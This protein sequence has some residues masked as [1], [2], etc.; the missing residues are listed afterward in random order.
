[1]RAFTLF[2]VTLLCACGTEHE[3]G[4]MT[5]R[6]RGLEEDRETR[7]GI[8]ASA[9]ED[10]TIGRSV[11][12]MRFVRN[13]IG[14]AGPESVKYDAEQDVWFVTNMNGAGSV[15]DG[16]G[17]I[18][19]IRAAHPDSADVFIQGGVNG[20][21]LDGP[22]GMAIHGD[23]LWVAD[24]SVLRAFHRKT[25]APL[26]EIDFAPLGAVQLNDVAIGPDGRV[27]V[28]DTGIM[29]TPKG[30]LHIGPDRVF[31]VGPGRQVTTMPGS[32]GITY[33]NGITWDAGGKRW[34]VV[35]FD[36]F[37]GRIHAIGADGK[38]VVIRQGSSRL[39]G[40]EVLS[41]GAIVFTSWGD[42]T[43]HLVRNGRDE[44]A[45]R[46]I[47]EGADIGID[48]RRSQLAVPLSVLGRVQIWSL[49]GATPRSAQ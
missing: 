45:L 35:T 14:F 42:S 40:V 9:A 22:K 38:A 44:A 47:P 24:I 34:L 26:A 37:V 16:N 11:S 10:M 48:T 7:A 6:T 15:K 41:D 31:I 29:M 27:H 13:L 4:E 17:Y 33:P 36:P 39:D 12:G 25:G 23:T 5:E 20:V 21:T 18:S 28:T 19:R 30:V 49:P 46:E 32:E 2:L 1:M 43:L 3:R 8:R